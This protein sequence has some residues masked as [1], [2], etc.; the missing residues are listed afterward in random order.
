MVTVDVT[1]NEI[2]TNNNDNGKCRKISDKLD[3]KKLR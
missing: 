1:G 3:E 2:N